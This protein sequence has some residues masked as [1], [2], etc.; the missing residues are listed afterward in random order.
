M[1]VLEIEIEDTRPVAAAC[2]ETELTVE[3]ADGRRVVT[4]LWWYPRLL[5]A[6][7][8]DR[9]EIE[10]SPFGVHWPKI[11][12]DLSVAGMLKGAKAPGAVPPGSR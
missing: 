5:A 1:T 6:S 8:E 12:E 3:L 4:P 9:A 10:L 2:S 7:S 11:D